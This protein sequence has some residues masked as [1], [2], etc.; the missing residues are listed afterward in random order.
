MFFKPRTA[1]VNSYTFVKNN[2]MIRS[3]DEKSN[4]SKDY[5]NTKKACCYCYLFALP[6]IKI[7]GVPVWSQLIN[8][9]ALRKRVT[10][11]VI[12]FEF[13]SIID[14]LINNKALWKRV[15]FK[16]IDFEFCL[17]FDVLKQENVNIVKMSMIRF[18]SKSSRD[19]TH[20]NCAEKTDNETI[21]EEEAGRFLKYF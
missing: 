9:K 14:V 3:G 4:D 12:D 13:D 7:I 1:A 19:K 10:F 6:P 20:N 11:K 2:A 15:T 17:I 5:F 18:L 8:N 21:N 16:V